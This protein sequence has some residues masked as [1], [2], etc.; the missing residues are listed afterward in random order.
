MNNFSGVKP[1]KVHL[2]FYNPIFE[3]QVDED[4]LEKWLYLL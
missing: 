2:N 3:G 1:F 4:A